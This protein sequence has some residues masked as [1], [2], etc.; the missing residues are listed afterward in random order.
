MTA[1]K[2][3][4]RRSTGGGQIAFLLALS[5]ALLAVAAVALVLSSLGHGT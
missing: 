3:G 1:G 5:R 4:V 2:H